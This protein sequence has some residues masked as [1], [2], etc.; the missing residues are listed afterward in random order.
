MSSYINQRSCF[1]GD[2]TV[3]P[4]G[5]L[6]I[7]RNTEMGRYVTVIDPIAHGNPGEGMKEFLP[8]SYYL[9]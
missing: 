6:N 4:D 2:I 8:S 7:S 9:K 3:L 5:F 1:E